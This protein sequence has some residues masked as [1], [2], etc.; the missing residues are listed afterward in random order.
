[1]TGSPESVEISPP[2][3]ERAENLALALMD[4][5]ISSHSST[6]P[7][8]RNA[9]SHPTPFSKQR[10]FED[11]QGTGSSMHLAGFAELIIGVSN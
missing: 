7:S 4:P 9:N 10:K 3:G 5:G 1:M 8:V 2:P 11:P 6:W